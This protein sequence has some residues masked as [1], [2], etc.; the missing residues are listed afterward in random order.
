M[1]SRE[2]RKGTARVGQ[3]STPDEA[4]GAVYSGFGQHGCVGDLWR[5][6]ELSPATN[7]A[8]QSGAVSTL[9]AW[10]ECL[11]HGQL[12]SSLPGTDFKARR[13][14][15]VCAEMPTPGATSTF[16]SS[17]KPKS[18]VSSPATEFTLWRIAFCPCL[19]AL[20]AERRP[21]GVL[22]LRPQDQARCRIARATKIRMT[23]P[24][25][26]AARAVDGLK[27]ESPIGCGN[28]P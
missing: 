25:K 26:P 11:G 27:R 23:A 3:R 5:W 10:S 13:S 22:R 14:W 28:G 4:D 7:L 17:G 8:P 16:I 20:N 21:W 1:T 19:P 12:R 9:T 6:R 18:A 2:K 24:M 15:T